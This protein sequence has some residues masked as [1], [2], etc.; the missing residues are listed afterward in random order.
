MPGGRDACLQGMGLVSDCACLSSFVAGM[1]MNWQLPQQMGFVD[2]CYK[3]LSVPLLG[4]EARLVYKAQ[5]M[6]RGCC[7]EGAGLGTVP[8][9]LTTCCSLVPAPGVEA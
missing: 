6:C 7:G 4:L 1:L 3:R 9:G 8:G 2:I 5:T